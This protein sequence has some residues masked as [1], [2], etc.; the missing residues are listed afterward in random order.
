MISVDRDNRWGC[1]K[2]DCWQGRG[3]RSGVSGLQ[4]FH[5]EAVVPPPGRTEMHGSL[6]TVDN[7]LTDRQAQ[8]EYRAPP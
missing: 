4:E 3:E 7:L 8:P 1:K 5:D 6:V 2:P